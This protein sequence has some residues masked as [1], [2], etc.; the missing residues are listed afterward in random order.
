MVLSGRALGKFCS[1]QVSSSI[2]RI[3][4]GRSAASLILG[5]IVIGVVS[6]GGKQ[7]AGKRSNGIQS[8]TDNDTAD[9]PNEHKTI[10]DWLEY[11]GEILIL[12]C[13]IRYTCRRGVLLQF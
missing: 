10:D 11:S 4:M 7:R 13:V 9:I 3:I 6:G 2:S 8:I 12:I 1:R 5:V